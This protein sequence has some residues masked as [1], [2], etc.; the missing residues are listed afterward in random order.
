MLLKIFP[1][2]V[3]EKLIIGKNGTFELFITEMAFLR[4]L[5]RLLRVKDIRLERNF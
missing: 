5:D 3:S 2:E 4:R 1:S